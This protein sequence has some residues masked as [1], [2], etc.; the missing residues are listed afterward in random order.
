MADLGASYGSV[1]I[2]DQLNIPNALAANYQMQ[3]QR[4]AMQDQNALAQAVPLLQ[5][6]PQNAFAT[7]ARTSPKAALSL[8][9]VIQ[10]MDQQQKAKTAERTEALANM[11]YTLKSKYTDPVIRKA[12]AQSMAPIS[13]VHGATPAQLQSFGYTG[14]SL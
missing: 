5:S 2:S 6:D 11:A 4:Q 12:V 3:Q 7:A 1:P 14:A 8:L 10:Q 9:P 13:A